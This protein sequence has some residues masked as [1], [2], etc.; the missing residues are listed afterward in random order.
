M[1]EPE[2][3]FNDNNDNMDL[4]EDFLKYLIGYALEHCKDDIEFLAKMYDKELVE[5]L[6]FVLDNDFVRLSYTEGVKILRS[7]DRSSSFRL[8]GS[9]PAVGT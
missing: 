8:L 5:R 9:R 4:A 1:I 7:R 3:A 6:H 2:V